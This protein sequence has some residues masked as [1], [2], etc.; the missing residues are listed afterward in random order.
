MTHVSNSYFWENREGNTHGGQ[1]MIPWIH[2]GPSELVS[3]VLLFKLIQGGLDT[4]IN[5]LGFGYSRERERE[6]GGYEH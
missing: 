6:R 3:S 4:L 1:K 2:G 5:G